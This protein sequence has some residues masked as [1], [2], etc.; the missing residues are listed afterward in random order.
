MKRK[1][2]N[3]S[4]IDW[5]RDVLRPDEPPVQQRT[6]RTKGPGH[7][8]SPATASRVRRS[9]RTYTPAT[10]S[11]PTRQPAR[12]EASTT[13]TPPA[14]QKRQPSAPPATAPPT[15]QPRQPS[16][17]PA[18]TPPARQPPQPEASS[19]ATSPARQ[20][21][22]PDANPAVTPDT[23]QPP[24]PPH[25][26][27][28]SEYL[29]AVQ[30]KLNKIAEDFNGGTINRA[31]FQNLYAHYQREIRSIEGILELAPGSGS[32]KES[33][34]AGQSVIIRRQHAARAEGYAI[35]E[36]HSG[37]PLS[38]LGQFQ[39]DVDLLV[40]MLSSY[41]SAAQ[42]MFGAGIRSTQIDDGRWLCFVPGEFTTMMAVFTSEP[43][44]KQLE[45]LEDLHHLFE[46]ANRRTLATPPVDPGT[47]LFPHEYFLR[48]KSRKG[49]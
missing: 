2:K 40:P 10:A 39:I 44:S 21:R 20:P 45:Y 17:P 46:R 8:G 48:R 31:Q 37:L 35:Y 24:Q 16:A 36:D 19:P 13:A 25:I 26:A 18:T 49:G 27:Q 1:D 43:A 11:S 41:R 38:T 42:E 28:A 32:W 12:T 23:H 34:T 33:V 9:P 47:L 22:R 30:A 6:A 5:L 3:R 15:R 7:D 29:S 14:R 4:I